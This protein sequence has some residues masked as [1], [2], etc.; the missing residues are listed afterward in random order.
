MAYNNDPIGHALNSLG[1]KRKIEL[2]KKKLIAKAKK[3]GIYENFGQTEVRQLRDE[4]EWSSAPFPEKK[5]S[6]QEVDAFS[7][8]VENFDQRD[9]EELK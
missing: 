6:L 4:V 9:L 5:D 7:N 3:R 1:V 8:W 2:S